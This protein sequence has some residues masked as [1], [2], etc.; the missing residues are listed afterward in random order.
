VSTANDAGEQALP[1]LVPLAVAFLVQVSS[2]VFSARGWVALFPPDADRRMIA[3]GLYTSQLTKY[4]PAGGFM[5][6]ASQVALSSGQGGMATAA[7]R[8]PVF[9]M[10][11]I[12]AAATT[13]AFMAFSDDVPTWGRVAAGAA[14]VT[15]VL[16]DRRVLALALRAARRLVKRLP[17]A[18][19]LPPQRAIL[20]CYGFCLLNMVTYAAAFVILLGDMA[21]IEPLR[22]GA[23]LGAGW[24]AGYL[25]LPLPS[26]LGVR[27]GVLKLA[28]PGVAVGSLLGASFAHRLLGLLAEGL[29]AGQA[30]LRERLARRGARSATKP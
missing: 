8:L 12:V 18:T 28:L 14:L 7:L 4:L 30:H 9:S 19:S 15:L 20:V 24:A 21:D 17:E 3:R 13:G 11:S 26:G 16:L 25:V 5:Q 2:I 6:V 10:C 1:G 27:E 23:A 22:V 29:L